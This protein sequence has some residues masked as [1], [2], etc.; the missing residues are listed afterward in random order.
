MDHSTGGVAAAVGAAV[1]AQ[2]ALTAALFYWGRR[3]ALRQGGGRWTTA[4]W[5]P[6]WAGALWLAGLLGT[7]GGL[8]HA[9]GAVS[10]EPPED[11]ARV[12]ADGISTAMWATALLG[13]PSGLLYL[14][15]ILVFGMGTVRNG[16]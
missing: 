10:E 11:K 13:V 3:V 9:F 12:L 1:G 6:V 5:L 16:R 7:V 8:F 4:S 14:T 15:A 2:A